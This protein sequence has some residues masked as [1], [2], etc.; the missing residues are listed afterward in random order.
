MVKIV[1]NYQMPVVDEL[2]HKYILAHFPCPCVLAVKLASIRATVLFVSH[3]NCTSLLS[4][5]NL[6]I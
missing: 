4:D 2:T 5:S 3:T 1:Y 6:L